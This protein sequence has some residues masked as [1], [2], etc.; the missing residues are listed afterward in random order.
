MDSRTYKCQ[1]CRDSG[2]IYGAFG[3]ID[4]VNCSAANQ[5]R[6]TQDAGCTA[7]ASS[8]SPNHRWTPAQVERLL[9][10]VIGIGIAA[11]FWV[12]YRCSGQNPTVPKDDVAPATATSLASADFSPWE[13]EP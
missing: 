9:K 3:F 5:P 8:A 6:A 1:A 13:P 12:F 11:F 7:G 2:Y 4:C 10:I